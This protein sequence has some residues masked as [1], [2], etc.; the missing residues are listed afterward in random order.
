MTLASNVL[1]SRLKSPRCCDGEVLIPT[2]VALS[3][4][5][6]PEPA[7]FALIMLNSNLYWAGHHTI[8]DN[9]SQSTRYGG[10]SDPAQLRIEHENELKK[11]GDSFQSTASIIAVQYC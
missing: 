4:A 11:L 10:G 7:F 2:D 9:L 5:L 8:S 6:T 3:T 1:A